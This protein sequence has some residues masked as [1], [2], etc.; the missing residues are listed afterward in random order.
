M[1]LDIESILKKLNISIKGA[2]HV[3]AHHGNELNKYKKLKI[4][5]VL[6]YEANP[7]LIKILKVKKFFYEK[8]FKMNIFVEN[9]LIS[10]SL[11]KVKLNITSNSQCSSIYELGYHQIT[12][13]KVIKTGEIICKSSTL[14]NEFLIYDINNFNFLN[15]DIQGAELLALKGATNILSKLDVIYTEV[16]FVEMYR[17]CCLINEI[18]EFLLKF[19]FKRIF[20]SDGNHWGDAIYIKNN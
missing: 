10:N 19:N 5:N 15:M 6:L 9:K 20:T 1:L 12:N 16:N 7:K 17:N 14:N 11:E 2:I 18:D 3:G 8:C 4:K 13:P